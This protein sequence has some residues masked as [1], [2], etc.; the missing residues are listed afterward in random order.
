M[1]LSAVNLRQAARHA[2]L[3]EEALR[4]L[5]AD[6]VLPA[7]KVRGHYRILAED[8][9][10][11]LGLP[12]IQ[13]QLDTLSRQV[14]TALDGQAQL[15]LRVRALEEE[16]AL[17][18]GQQVSR[19]SV[20]LWLERHGVPFNTVMQW[21]TIPRGDPRH[22]DALRF[23]LDRLRSRPS[24]STRWRIHTC[25]DAECVCHEILP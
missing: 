12:G 22:A 14:T 18:R 6:G 24:L 13:E 7:Q 9:M 3:S 17:L 11:A 23:V 1:R 21:R 15:V 2:G 25:T 4:Q 19:R 8:L 10:H 20:A 16:I 5:I